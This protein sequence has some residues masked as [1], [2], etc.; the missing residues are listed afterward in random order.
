MQ[1]EELLEGARTGL[2]PQQAYSARV[3]QAVNRSLLDQLSELANQNVASHR[4]TMEGW[5]GF[6]MAKPLTQLR[7]YVSILRALFTDAKVAHTGEYY[8]ANFAFNGYAPRTDMP[9]MISGLSPKTLHFAG[10]SCDGVILWSCL[11]S[12]IRD[13]VVPAVRAG[14]RES[15]RPEGS[16]EIIAAV[17]FHFLR[18]GLQFS[19]FFQFRGR[20]KL[21][22]K[23]AVNFFENFYGFSNGFSFN[24]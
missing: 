23:H 20:S 16:C 7:E 17:F 19:Q 6:D 21:P 15:G 14:E 2:S 12:Y 11:P 22:R 5:Y 3:A 1:I 4:V 8:T 13:T 18:Q 10:A 24:R 9:I